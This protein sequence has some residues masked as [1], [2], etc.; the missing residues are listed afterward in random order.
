LSEEPS[1][2]GS[3]ATGALAKLLH[4]LNLPTLG[5]IML[6]GGG[7][8][9]ATKTTSDEQR[10]DILRAIREVHELHEAL[11]DFEKRQKQALDNQNQILERLKPNGP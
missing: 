3:N 10:G 11:D 5:M 9:F 8:F 2:N 4:Q 6:M 1:E 7:N